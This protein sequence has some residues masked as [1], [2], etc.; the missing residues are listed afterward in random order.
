MA[1]DDDAAAITVDRLSYLNDE[2]RFAKVQ[3]EDPMDY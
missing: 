2:A 3:M 1:H